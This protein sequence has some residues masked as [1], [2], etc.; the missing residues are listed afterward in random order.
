MSRK[1]IGITQQN[2]HD[3]IE[4]PFLFSSSIFLFTFFFTFVS[5]G[6]KFNKENDLDN[7][8]GIY[9]KYIYHFVVNSFGFDAFHLVKRSKRKAETFVIFYANF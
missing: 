2:L 3:F 4:F 9:E 5:F 1:L 6:W 7:K 8:I